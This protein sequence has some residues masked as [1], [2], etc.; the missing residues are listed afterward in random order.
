MK[1]RKKKDKPS[2]VL[3]LNLRSPAKVTVHDASYE[4]GAKIKQV[5]EFKHM[6]NGTLK[7]DGAL[8]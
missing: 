1:P 7:P 2:F 6:Q 8:V 4:F 5:E 3:W